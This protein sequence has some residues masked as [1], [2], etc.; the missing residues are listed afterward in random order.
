MAFTATRNLAAGTKVK[1]AVPGDVPE[2]STWDDDG[3]RI[4]GNLKK[5]L[6]GLFFAG[7]PK[8]HAEIMYVSRESERARLRRKGLVKVRLRDPAGCSLTITADPN[9]LVTAR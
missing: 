9:N 6:Q 7:N 2:Y 3:G 1:V 4:S 5:R 8:I